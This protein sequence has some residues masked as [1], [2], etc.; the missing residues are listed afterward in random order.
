MHTVLVELCTGCEL[1]LAPC[2]VDCIQMVPAS[3]LGQPPAA[4]SAASNRERFE[5]HN[6]RSERRAR[7]RNAL[8][9]ARTS[10]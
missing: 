10:E 7:E 2:P 4:P 3:T 6:A 5:A 8:L 9:E 1:C